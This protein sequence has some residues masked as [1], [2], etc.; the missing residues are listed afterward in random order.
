MKIVEKGQRF[1]VPSN[2][3]IPCPLHDFRP[4]FAVACVDCCHYNGVIDTED[5][6]AAFDVRYRIFCAHPIARRMQVIIGG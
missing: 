6:A 5:E 1:N 4:V 3:I 2:V